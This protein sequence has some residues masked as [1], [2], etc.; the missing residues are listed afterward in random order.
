[1]S[2]TVTEEALVR[3]LLDQQAALLSLATSESTIISKLGATKVTLADLTAATVIDDADLLLIRQGTTEKSVSGSVVKSLGSQPNASETVKGIV[4]LATI[5]ET[6]TGTDATRAV[7]PAGLASLTA[8]ETR[9]GLIALATVA[10]AQAGTN[11]QKVITPLRLKEAQIRAAAS[12]TCAGQTVIDFVG[13]PSWVKRIT[14]MFNG[15]STSGTSGIL[16]QIGSGSFLTSG[17]ASGSEANAQVTTSTAGFVTRTVV[18][19]DV[20]SGGMT[21]RLSD[22]TTNFWNSEHTLFRTTL[23]ASG[24]GH[25]SLS[26]AL[27]R[28][29]IT[30]VNG[31]DAFDTTPSAGTINILFE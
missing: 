31:T 1:M 21:M 8:T 12:V 6:I 27:D 26:G 9:S 13:I 24:G 2:L 16:V 25:V 19:S 29:R 20:I 10:E 30:T 17:Y 14:V 4:E 15:V 7:H 18:A 11:N 28:V 22:A 5:A 23:S 3:Q